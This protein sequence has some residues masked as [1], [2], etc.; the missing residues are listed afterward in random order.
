MTCSGQQ[1]TLYLKKGLTEAEDSKTY[2]LSATEVTQVLV[3][4]VIKK[5]DILLQEYTHEN[6]FP[7]PFSK[8]HI[9]SKITIKLF[10]FSAQITIF[11]S[12]KKS[13]EFK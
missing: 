7:S 13:Q 8:I 3:C 4:F 10:T 12:P 1:E 6:K 9:T 11:I 5:G 2:L